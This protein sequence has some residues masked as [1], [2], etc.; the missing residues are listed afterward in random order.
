MARGHGHETETDDLAHLA[1]AVNLG[2]L[3]F[4][5]WPYHADDHCVGQTYAELF[6]RVNVILAASTDKGKNFGPPQSAGCSGEPG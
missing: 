5:P 1:W 4:H 2:C 6:P 3:G